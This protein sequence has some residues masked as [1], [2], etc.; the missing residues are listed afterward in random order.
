MQYDSFYLSLIDFVYEECH[1]EKGLKLF[2]DFLF[3]YWEL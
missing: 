3:S 1:L 2:V